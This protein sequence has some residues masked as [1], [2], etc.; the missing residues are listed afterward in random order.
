VS[1]FPLELVFSDVWGPAIE[2]VG[3]RK[4]YVSFIDDFSKFVWIYTLKHKTEVF[5]RFHEFQSIVERLFDRKILAMQTD[6]GGEYQ[7]LNSFF[8]RI[9]ISH[10]VSC[11]HAHQQNRSARAHQQNESAERKHHHI[12]E[13]GL[14]LLAQASMPLKFWDEAFTIAVYLINRT[15]SKVVGYETPL[16]CLFHTK[17]NY[18][19]LWVF[20]CA[21]WPNLHPYNNHKLQFRSKQC[22]FLGYSTQHKGFKCL[23][24]VE[25][26]IYI[27]RDVVFDETIYPFAKLN[28]NAGARLRSEISLLPCSPLSGHNDACLT[29]DDLTL[30]NLHTNDNLGQTTDRVYAGDLGENNEENHEENEAE[31]SPNEAPAAPMREISPLADTISASDQVPRQSP[32]RISVLDQAQQ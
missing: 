7:R 28:P 5:E 18:L 19:S 31:L 15:P 17:P 32:S 4:Y 8:Q 16:E 1:K 25:G 2:S 20:G 30:T 10:H 12:V 23:D 11:A 3:R 24:I 22:A 13:V 21:C 26:R 27:L 29:N 9:G 6:W 14:T